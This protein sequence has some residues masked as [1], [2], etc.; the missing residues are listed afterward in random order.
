MYEPAPPDTPRGVTIRRGFGCS[1]RHRAKADVESEGVNMPTPDATSF[2][3]WMSRCARVVITE[4]GYD[5]TGY[6]PVE[7]NPN[8][9]TGLAELQRRCPAGWRLVS[10][11]CPAPLPGSHVPRRLPWLPILAPAGHHATYRLALGHPS[12]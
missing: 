3:C 4:L 12:R 9:A 2:P 10:T 5:A 11:C 6:H 7:V 8:V 1:A